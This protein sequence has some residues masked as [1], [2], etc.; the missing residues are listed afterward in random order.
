[1]S[2][3]VGMIADDLTGALDA[4]APFAAQGLRTMVVIAPDGLERDDPA[5]RDAEVICINT[6]SREIAAGE[7][8]RRAGAAME[9]LAALAPKL[10]FK[11]LDSRL[12]G[13]VAV[14]L[15][16]V[17]AASGRGHAV[18]AP[19]I[20]DLGRLVRNGAVCGMGVEGPIAVAPL[21]GGLPVSVPDTENAE[22]MAI[23]AGR[24]WDE[25]GHVVAAGARGLAQALAVRFPQR[26]APDVTRPLPHKLLIAIGSRDPITRAQ[27]DH[28]MAVAA[29]VR[30]RAP[31]G[32][33]PQLALTAPVTLVTA[34]RGETAEAGDVV[35][36]RFAAGLAD[37]VQST[38]PAAMLISGGETAYA[39]LRQLGAGTILLG[40]EAL[41]GVPF[42][43]AQIGGKTVQILTKSGGFGPRDTISLLTGVPAELD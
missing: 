19:A 32:H 41:P 24:L 28:V 39:L 11:K 4:C 8:G 34:E 3:K 31:N 35:A 12:K 37:M 6:A 10:V 5:L 40:G 33:V 2:L 27:V 25:A 1:M 26:L 23:V 29:P 42:G 18:L 20:P 22:A 30:V 9:V 38:P 13:H 21:C 16:A 43:W 15:G 17:L 14:E 7:A 36:A